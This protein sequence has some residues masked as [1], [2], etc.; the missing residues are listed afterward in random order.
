MRVKGRCRPSP[1][2][3]G[4]AEPANQ[5]S[6]AFAVA[7]EFDRG[8]RA[9]VDAVLSQRLR[10]PVSPPSHSGRFV[11]L[12]CAASWVLICVSH[13][14]DNS[15]YPTLAPVVFSRTTASSGANHYSLRFRGKV[16]LDCGSS[17]VY[18]WPRL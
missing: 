15:F 13:S 7:A 4:A 16:V 11:P 14:P 12:K 8:H 17:S 1:N 9:H 3:A 2:A 6:S 10:Q 18:L 5:R